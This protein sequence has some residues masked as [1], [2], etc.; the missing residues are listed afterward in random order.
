MEQPPGYISKTHPD[1]ACKLKKALYGLKQAPRVWYGKIAEYLHFCG[2]VASHSD[3]SL[4][5][6]NSRNLHMVVLL[7]LDDMIDGKEVANLRSELSARFEMK[8]LGELSH[9]LGLEM[10]SVKDGI[11][12]TQEGYAKKLVDEF[13]MKNSKKCFTPLDANAKVNSNEGSLLLDPRPFHALVGSLLYLTI[14]RL[15]IVFSVNFISRFIQ[16]PRK[17]HLE[18]AKKILKYINTTCDKGLLY[19]SGADFLLYG[20]TDADL[21]GDLDDLKSTSGYVFLCGSI[22]VSWCSRKQDSVSLSTTEVKYKA[23]ALAAQECVWLR[24]LVEDVYLPI[25]EPT[26]VFGDNQSAI[27][28]ASNPVCHSR[29][30]HIELKHHFTREKVLDGTI[31]VSDIR[32]DEN[33]ADILTKALPKAAFEVFRTKLGLVSQ[34]SL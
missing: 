23:A 4:F 31:K 34:K 21:G 30:K 26:E 25:S 20:Y 18:A 9:F 5:M 32:S 15:D 11:F 33:V 22:G 10:K 27:K 19:K 8:D 24:R 13:G 3:S 29:T 17:P 14:S 12:L 28:L 1:F 2:Y 6:K 16:T 7:Y